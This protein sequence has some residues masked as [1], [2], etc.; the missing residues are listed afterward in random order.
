VLSVG[1]AK[2]GRVVLQPTPTLEDIKK[3]VVG[4]FE[5]VSWHEPTQADFQ[6][7]KKTSMDVRVTP[8]QIKKA[9]SL[10][11]AFTSRKHTNLPNGSRAG[12]LPDHEGFPFDWTSHFWGSHHR[13]PAESDVI[14]GNDASMD[15]IFMLCKALGPGERWIASH[16]QD[17]VIVAG[18][19]LSRTD[20][21]ITI[22]TAS[23]SSGRRKL[24]RHRTYL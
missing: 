14:T 22:G 5:F 12:A 17:C 16:S 2:F 20:V 15:E 8:T 21:P 10:D 6:S 19:T 18:V 9:Q 7:V 23:P 4:S 11:R 1:S 3:G 24:F 13:N